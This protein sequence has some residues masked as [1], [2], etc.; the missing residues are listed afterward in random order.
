MSAAPL[1]A[2]QNIVKHYGSVE[3]LRGASFAVL[4]GEVVALIGDNGAGKSTL[5][6]CMSGVEQPD[7]GSITIA[8]E[9]IVLDS[10]VAARRLGIE[11]VYQ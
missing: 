11:T 1:L 9:S 7:S 2:A 10:P 8:G 3:A 4:A 6:K 5:V